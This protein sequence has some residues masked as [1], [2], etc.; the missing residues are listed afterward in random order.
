MAIDA[1][2]A[3]SWLKRYRDLLTEIEHDL[4]RADTLRAKAA[5][6][7]SPNLSGMPSTPK[8]NGDTSMTNLTARAIDIEAKAAQ[9]AAQSDIMYRDIDR[10]INSIRCRG[11]EQMVCLLQLKYL[12]GLEWADITPTLFMGEDDFVD[13]EDSYTRRMFMIHKK[14]LQNLAELMGEKELQETS[15]FYGDIPKK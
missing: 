6:P 15:A 5:L 14:A 12:D 1:E 3:K 4:S 13:R 9:K 7:S 2:N 8:W 10:M 11:Y